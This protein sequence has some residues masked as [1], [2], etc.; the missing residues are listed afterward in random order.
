M[1]EISEHLRNLNN[2]NWNFSSSQASSLNGIPPFN[3]RKYHWFPSTFIP[4][5]P[6]TLIE[7][8]TSPKATVFDPFAGI[9]T[10]YFQALILN[11][12]PLATENCSV[13][14]EFMNSML[15][16]FDVEIDYESKRS[17]INDAIGRFDPNFDYVSYLVE[18]KLCSD[19]IMKLKPWFSARTLNE[20]MFIYA[21]G[22]ESKDDI[23]KSINKI[24]I[25]SILKRM[26]S[27]DR[28][29]GCIA[30]NVLP[31]QNQFKDKKAIEEVRKNS[32]ILIRDISLHLKLIKNNFKNQEFSSRKYSII[33]DDIR[34]TNLIENDSID[35]VITSPPYPNMTDY[36]TSQRLSY[37]FL[38]LDMK[39][40]LESEIGARI[41]RF[42]KSSVDIYYQNMMAA[43]QNISLKIKSGGF[44]CFIL[45]YFNKDD[46]NNIRRREA[47]EKL[48]SNLV[49][50]E[51]RPYAEYERIVPP[52]RRSHNMKWATLEREKI[53]IFRKA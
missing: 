7:I 28:G 32:N 20:L 14:V 43:N 44:A 9:G 24:S 23:I 48:I 19:S 5:I 15:S 33:H 25:S 36:V 10:T 40:D 50:F 27:Q 17:Y 21:D 39:Q 2:V 49:E 8:L 47:I 3:C 16:L 1:A 41:K 45:P 52:K 53:C 34:K 11:R 46:K 22:I 4:E 42:K 13:T 30:D 18:S 6:F 51:L 35:L 37:Y 31:K 29:W 38:G 26:S 12:V